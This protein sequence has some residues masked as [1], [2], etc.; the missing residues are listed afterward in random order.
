MK[1]KTDGFQE[2]FFQ[3]SPLKRFNFSK[4]YT[5]QRCPFEYK[6]VYEDVTGIKY[7]RSTPNISCGDILHYTL[8]DF[9]NNKLTKHRN[10]DNLLDLLDKNWKSDGFEDKLIEE[11][12]YKTSKEIL[13]KFYSNAALFANPIGVENRFRVI[14]D[15]IILT[16]IIDRIIIPKRVT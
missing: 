3:E 6:S 4:I 5:Y 9:F 11:K 13:N 1:N 15:D 12:W 7:R 14:V 10:L 2:S 8:R 16:G